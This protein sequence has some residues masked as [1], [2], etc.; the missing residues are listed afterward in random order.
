MPF[1]DPKVVNFLLR[2]CEESRSV[3]PRWNDGRIE[4]LHAVYERDAAMHGVSEAISEQSR[5]MIG[6]VEHT[7]NVRFVS[8]E[9]EIKAIDPSLKTFSNFNTPRDFASLDRDSAD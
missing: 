9:N 6:L 7:P 4:P 1:V 2:Q 3:V 8:V 5:S